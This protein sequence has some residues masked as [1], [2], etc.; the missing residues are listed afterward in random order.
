M[1]ASIAAFC[2]P[3]AV[4]VAGA[5]ESVETVSVERRAFWKA[6][7]SGVWK[8]KDEVNRSLK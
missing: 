6:W 4:A 8:S 5:E 1:E 3:V 2:T 7:V